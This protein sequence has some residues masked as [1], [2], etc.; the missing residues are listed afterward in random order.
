MSAADEPP[1]V[2]DDRGHDRL[3]FEQNGAVAELVYEVEADRLVLV[4]TEVPEALS[5]HGVGGRLVAAAVAKA[6][7]ESLVV[8]PRCPFARRWLQEHPDAAAGVTIDWT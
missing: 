8:V 3:A 1:T 4:H 2:V 6:R 7:A 5:G